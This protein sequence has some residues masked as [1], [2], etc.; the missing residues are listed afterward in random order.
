MGW[1]GE[2]EFEDDQGCGVTAQV[3]EGFPARPVPGEIPAWSFP[4][5]AA[6]RLGN[7]LGTL[8]CDLPARRLAAV[9]LVLD[10]GAL[11]EPDGKDGVA[12]LTAR[13]LTEGTH[14]RSAAEFAAALE[15]LGA[16]LYASAD[17]TAVRLAL[18]VPVTHLAGA[19]ELLA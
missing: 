5:A 7:G 1:D 2:G 3:V 8:R 4:E 6:G 11:R 16:S 19:L 14:S 10:A 15:R 9:R 18:D 12:T 13:A 17:L